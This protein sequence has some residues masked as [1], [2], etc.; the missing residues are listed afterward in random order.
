MKRLLIL[1]SLLIA[2]PVLAQTTP[3]FTIKVTPQD[4]DILW[5]A[6]RELPVKISEPVMQKIRQQIMEQSN[7]PSAVISPNTMGK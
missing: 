2:T 7:P 1:S 5:A 3:E 6:L 4:A